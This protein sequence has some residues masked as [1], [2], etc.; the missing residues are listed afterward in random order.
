M[1]SV[2]LAVVLAAVAGCA[3]T[4]P[5]STPTVAAPETGEIPALVE[6]VAR[7][8]NPAA[9]K[10]L[11]A[12]GPR[13]FEAVLVAYDAAKNDPGR[14]ANLSRALDTVA[15]Q[16]D[17]HAARLYW[18]TDL[19]EAKA[20][21]KATGR[22]ILSL[23]LLG[24]LDEEL[25]CANSR[26]FLTALYSNHDVSQ[27]LRDRF[28]LHWATERPAPLI[29]IDFRDGR[30]IKRTVTGNSLHYVLD[31]EGRVVDAIPGLYGPQAFA[32]AVARA[33]EVALLTGVL[34]ESERAKGLAVWHEESLR[35]ARRDWNRSL[36]ENGLARMAFPADY[37]PPTTR[38]AASPPP[39]AAVAMPIAPSKAAVE[40]PMIKGT[41]RPPELTV[42][43]LPW[44]RIGASR[45]AECKLD[46]ASIA[47]VK[48]KRPRSWTDG[49]G[50]GRPLAD[51]E[52]DV[53]VK[54]FE[55]SMSAD[56][57][58][59]EL[60]HHAV[61]HR[62]LADAART[63]SGEDELARLNTRVY[64]ELFKTPASDPWLGLVPPSV[65]TGIQDDGI[66]Q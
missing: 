34:E 8:E 61:I 33:G 26:F 25:S 54:G 13:G 31:A 55:V 35:V 2:V 64:A 50:M 16:K 58:K 47:L 19:D 3:S 12:A 10:Q 41:M 60:V 4:R 51:A 52:L 6:A 48:E 40:M 9:T 20:R 15:G 59:N 14:R 45:L 32:S 29:T 39:P 36:S 53:L 27:M 30:T 65:F 43:E 44:S 46:A 17:A 18:S 66:A 23:R 57:A 22:P 11:R 38:P 24:R 37:V 62:W 28:V 63:R 7:A 42:P 56:T 21:A 1:R 5:P 49:D